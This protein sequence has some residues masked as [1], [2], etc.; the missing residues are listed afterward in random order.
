MPEPFL[1]RLRVRSLRDGLPGSPQD[2]RDL[3]H[4]EPEGFGDT[5]CRETAG[6]GSQISGRAYDARDLPQRV[7]PRAFGALLQ[8]FRPRPFDGYGA[9]P[10][11]LRK[12]DCVRRKQS[13]DG[14]KVSG[15][16]AASLVEE[17]NH[18]P[19][20]GGVFRPLGEDP[21]EHLLLHEACRRLR[22][23]DGKSRK[24]AKGA[25]RSEERR[26]GKEC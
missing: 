13:Q 5:I 8:Y 14:R 25:D 3:C 1:K 15:L 2:L 23:N 24:P 10:C 12:F 11:T 22:L 17:E 21:E 7:T 26:V 16:E 9:V 18:P 19:G 20:E 6:F 4:G